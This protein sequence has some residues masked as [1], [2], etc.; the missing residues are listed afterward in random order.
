MYPKYVPCRFQLFFSRHLKAIQNSHEF[1]NRIHT[2]EMRVSS[3]VYTIDEYFIDRRM[4]D[5][6]G[7]NALNIIGTPLK[8]QKKGQKNN[9]IETILPQFY[10]IRHAFLRV[11]FQEVF[12]R[13]KK[14]IS[15]R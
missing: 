5:Y 13:L 2:E 12:K 7:Y 3:I 8:D 4:G 10:Y 11:T 6:P 1:K 15:S 14:I 9:T